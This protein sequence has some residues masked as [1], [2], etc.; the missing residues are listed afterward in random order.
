MLEKFPCFANQNPMFRVYML[1]LVRKCV[2]NIVCLGV[3]LAKACR[4]VVAVLF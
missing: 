4:L 1:L 3:L 2:L